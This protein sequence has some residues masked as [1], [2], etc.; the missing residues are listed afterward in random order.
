MALLKVVVSCEERRK[1]GCG[2]KIVGERARA[3]ALL[4]SR[5]VWPRS[6]I[7]WSIKPSGGRAVKGHSLGADG[8]SLSKRRKARLC[9]ALGSC[10]FR[11]RAPPERQRRKEPHARE[12]QREEFLWVRVW[13]LPFDFPLH[14]QPEMK[15]IRLYV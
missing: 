8:Q 9:K 6:M 7:R 11:Q 1:S 3:R 2:L 14:V 5:C 12:H 13:E 15:D 4:V 10:K